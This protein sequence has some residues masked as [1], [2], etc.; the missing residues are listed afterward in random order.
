M[1]FTPI[2]FAVF[3]ALSWTQSPL[4][5][6]DYKRET[7]NDAGYVSIFNGK[8][9]DGWHTSAA[10]GHSRASKNKSGGRWVGAHLACSDA[11]APSVI[12][13]YIPSTGTR[14]YQNSGGRCEDAPCC[15]CCT[16]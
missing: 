1:R 11:G 7:F 2:V 10:S 6:E 5:A 4:A 3:A 16:F 9:L 12:E 15:G 8:T 14:L 13:V